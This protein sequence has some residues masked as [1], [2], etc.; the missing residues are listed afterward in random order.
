MTVRYNF[1]SNTAVVTGTT[2]VRIFT[3]FEKL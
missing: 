3:N 1:S 2:R